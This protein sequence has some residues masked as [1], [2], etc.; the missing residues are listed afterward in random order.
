MLVLMYNSRSTKCSKL[1]KILHLKELFHIFKI[2]KTKT[3]LWETV[4]PFNKVKIISKMKIQSLS[5]KI[6]NKFHFQMISK[7]SKRNYNLFRNSRK[8]LKSIIKLF[9]QETFQ[10]NQTII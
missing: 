9:K 3:L 10:V 6:S 2:R 1:H 4:N 8:I 7:I 5:L